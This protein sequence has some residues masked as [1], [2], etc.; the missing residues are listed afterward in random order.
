MA[1]TQTTR[2]RLALASTRRWTSSSLCRMDSLLPGSGVRYPFLSSRS[3]WQRLGIPPPLLRGLKAFLYQPYQRE[4]NRNG[5]VLCP[6]R[7]ARFSL[8]RTAPHRLRCERL[9]VSAGY[10]TKEILKTSVSFWL[11][12]SMTYFPAL[13]CKTA[14]SC[15]SSLGTPLYRSVSSFKKI[16]AV[17][18]VSKAGTGAGSLLFRP[19]L[20]GRC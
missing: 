10:S 13:E 9:F 15:S 11:R 4:N 19:L 3:P 8:V 1:L 17:D 2:F 5:R 18:Q 14:C 20:M 16:F 7:A 6:V 12:K